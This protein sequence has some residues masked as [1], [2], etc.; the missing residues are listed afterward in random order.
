VE[1]SFLP[2]YPNALHEELEG[3]LSLV[4]VGTRPVTAEVEAPPD[5]ILDEIEVELAPGTPPRR[6]PFSF[7]APALNHWSADILVRCAGTKAENV[8]ISCGARPYLA[9]AEEKLDLLEGHTAP[10]SV[11]VRHRD[12]GPA[13]VRKVS[14]HHGRLEVIGGSGY[15]S[16]GGDLVL[17]L[18]FPGGASAPRGVFDE[19][20]ELDLLN[21]PAVALPL[22]VVVRELPC[23]E[24][25]ATHLD[26][27]NVVIGR[28]R[29]K[30]IR[31]S[32]VGGGALQVEQVTLLDRGDT[33]EFQDPGRPPLVLRQSGEVDLV[34]SVCPRRPEPSRARLL[35]VT[36]DPR[37][38]EVQVT[39]TAA[40]VLELPKYR[41]LVG[42]DFGT[43]NS[44]ISLLSP[45]GEVQPL[46]LDP[47][48][49]DP[50]ERLVLSS[51]VYWSAPPTPGN[52][53]DCTVGRAALERAASPLYARSTATSIK[54]KMGRREPERILGVPLLPQEIAAR[55]IR[56]LVDAAEDKLGQTVSRAVVTVPANFTPPQVR[57]T[58]QACTLAGLD[59]V[60][61]AG[62]LMDEPVGAALDYLATSGQRAGDSPYTLV[63]DFGGGTLDISIIHFHGVGGVQRLDVLATKGDTAFGGDDLTEMLRRELQRRAEAELR[64]TVP[65][66]PPEG[67]EAI[68]SG[69]LLRCHYENY[70]ALR[71][72]AEGMKRDLSDRHETTDGCDLLVLRGRD[73]QKAYRKYTVKRT[74]Y[75]ELIR[76]RLKETRKLVDRAL[77]AANLREDQV[78]R[79]LLV[80]KSSR[81]P[82]VA[83]LLGNWFGLKPVLHPEPK[84]CV[85]RGAC[86]KGE[87][88]SNPQEGHLLAVREL[89]RTNCR[90]GIILFREL[91]RQFQPIIGERESFPAAGTYPHNGNPLSIQPGGRITVALNRGEDDLAVDNP[92]IS[93]LGEITVD[94]ESDAVL[95]L[96]VALRVENH[97]SIA[98]EVDVGG[99][100]TRTVRFEEY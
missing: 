95:S 78:N 62:N 71:R 53:R 42:I 25:N 82:L 19:I 76:P 46:V 84:V 93:P 77:R 83:D 49:H 37:H 35:V 56:H 88:V 58:V 18:R 39:L 92:D 68:P 40:G 20:L 29:A 17:Q 27:G 87:L 21:A 6:I 100:S 11:V 61:V 70:T 24:I 48:A 9:L 32:N 94:E 60:V 13:F 2:F 65:A 52:L 91:R 89:D 72:L 30:V 81:T 69:E 10:F 51:C 36:N 67:W 8:Q 44:C 59:E 26:F 5:F 79:V 41:G 1:E 80:G 54:R 50:E 34:V 43:S 22:A 63:Y 4:N 45:G 23:L 47:A 55:I 75:E 33:W 98:V 38:R 28:S 7:K 85:S 86:K 15:V 57:A 90:Y 64:A 74:E 96:R 3:V 66:D 99:G 16:P 31:L 97:R 14:T 12:G 73:V